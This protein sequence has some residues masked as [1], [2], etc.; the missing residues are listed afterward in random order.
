MIGGGLLSAYDR[1]D[2]FRN[3]KHLKNAQPA[4][5]ADLGDWGFAP[6][7]ENPFR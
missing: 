3:E 7:S 5:N 4:R 6:T 1:R 2:I